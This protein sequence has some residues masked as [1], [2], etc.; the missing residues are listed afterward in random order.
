MT[1]MDPLLERNAHFSGTPEWAAAELVPRFAV[2]VISCL[3]PRVDPTRFLELRLGDATVVRNVGGRVSPAVLA[4][5]AY[6]GY[7]QG[8]VVPGGPAFEVVV[9]HHNQCGT[10]F[11]AEPGFRH[12]FADLMGL[13]DESA[14]AAEAVV[15]PAVTVRADVD[16]VLGY[17]PLP[18]TITVSGRVYDVTTGRLTTVV[19][20]TAM[21]ATAPA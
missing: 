15:N 6:I 9:V 12:G 21:P 3:D 20:A 1:D 10:H 5:L 4:D 7:L 8:K 2:Y 13:D 18:R 19:P 16:L 17:A 11:L 14:L